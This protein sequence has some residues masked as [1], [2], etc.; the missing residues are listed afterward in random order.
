[1]TFLTQLDDMNIESVDR[2]S[3]FG[4]AAPVNKSPSD[5]F[6]QKVTDVAVRKVPHPK[7]R[8]LLK[9]IFRKQADQRRVLKHSRVDFGAVKDGALKDAELKWKE[10]FVAFYG[11]FHRGVDGND[12]SY[13]ARGQAPYL[14]PSLVPTSDP[15]PKI[16]TYSSTPEESVE[17]ADE[18][19]TEPESKGT[20]K[21]SKELVVAW[22]EGLNENLRE[23]GEPMISISQAWQMEQYAIELERQ[24]RK[25]INNFAKRKAYEGGHYRI[26]FDGRLLSFIE[27][28][29]ADHLMLPPRNAVAFLDILREDLFEQSRDGPV[30]HGRWGSLS[31]DDDSNDLVLFLEKRKSRALSKVLRG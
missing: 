23:A 10:F 17:P 16:D 18:K 12:S 13:T 7:S 29:F 30:F 20:F 5:A 11:G 8:N 26:T 24:I 14:P 6:E 2:D 15:E 28:L 27:S 25:I 22:L 4:D 9:E 21:A 31:I 19:S 1:M 3:S